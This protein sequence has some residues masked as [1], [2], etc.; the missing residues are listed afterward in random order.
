MIADLSESSPESI[1]K[2]IKRKI[3]LPDVKQIASLVAKCHTETEAAMLCGFSAKQWFKWKERAKSSGK[4]DVLLAGMKAN[5][6]NGNLAQI[7]KAANGTHGIRHDWRAADR[8]NAIIAP[9]R[10]AQRAE[11]QTDAA[12]VMLL[13]ADAMNKIASQMI[14]ERA[15]L[16]AIVE[17]PVVEVEPLNQSSACGLISG[18]S[19]DNNAV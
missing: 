3:T 4:F 6:I 14:A 11:S 2:P 16:K 15:R 7:E 8:L 17:C 9:E 5:Y 10:F 18:Q 19:K 12:K 13:T 1:L